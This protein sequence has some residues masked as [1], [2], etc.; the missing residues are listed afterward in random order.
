MVESAPNAVD[1]EDGGHQFA[2]NGVDV[3]TPRED[4]SDGFELCAVRN[5][6]DPG[7]TLSGL[8]GLEESMALSRRSKID[9]VRCDTDWGEVGMDELAT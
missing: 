2:G 8:V 9:E 6:G 4:T 3:P 1:P 5:Q 7:S